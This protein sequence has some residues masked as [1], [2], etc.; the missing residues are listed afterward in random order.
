MGVGDRR[1]LRSSDISFA[2]RL[3][4]GMGMYGSGFAMVCMCLHAAS[5]EDAQG[6]G[7]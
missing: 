2:E 4:V 3:G 7:L 6:L 5:A 1:W